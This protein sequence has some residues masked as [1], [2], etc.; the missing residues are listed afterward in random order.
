MMMNWVRSERATQFFDEPPDV[1]LVE[2]SVDLGRGRKI[3][4]GFAWSNAKSNATAVSERSPPESSANEPSFFPGGWA[5]ISMPGRPV[6]VGLARAP[7][8][9]CRRG[10]RR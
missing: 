8:R 4:E 1:G 5:K 2:R 7:R 9:A 10:R 6:L 3:G